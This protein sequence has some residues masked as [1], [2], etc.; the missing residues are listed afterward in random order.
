MVMS[1]FWQ[2]I[3]VPALNLSI[4]VKERIYKNLKNVK[5]CLINFYLLSFLILGRSCI[6]TRLSVNS[7]PTTTNIKRIGS[8]RPIEGK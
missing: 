3:K 1:V 2:K 4:S 6:D 7:T 8:P 5:L